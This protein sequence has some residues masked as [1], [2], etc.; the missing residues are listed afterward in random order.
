[1]GKFW[2]S[3]LIIIITLVLLPTNWWFCQGCLEEE[4]FALLQLKSNINNP[5]G[6]SLSSWIDNNR[7]DCCEWPNVVCDTSTKR[8]VQISLN[9]TR[10]WVVQGDWHF[11]ASLFL[12]FKMLRVLSLE[13]T[14]M[15]G[16][17]ENQGL[18][19]LPNSSKLEILNLE[20]NKFNRS[21]LLSLSGLTSLKSL[22]LGRNSLDGSGDERLQNL[23]RLEFLSLDGTGISDLQSVCSIHDF[24]N[25]K[26]LDISQNAF[27][28]L[29]PMHGIA[30]VSH[31]QVLHLDSLL[32]G[33]TSNYSNMIQSLSVLSS[34]NTLY[35][36]HNHFLETHYWKNLSKLENLFLDGSYLVDKNV[37]NNIGGL[38]SLKVIS[39]SECGLSGT[40][41]KQGWCEL[42][43]I[44]ELRL[45]GNELNGVLPPC[46][47][48]L[49]S[50]RL[51]DLSSNQFFGN[52]AISPLSRLTSLESLTIS[53]NQFQVPFSFESFSNHSNLKFIF[54]ANNEVILETS[55]KN[56][57]PSF[58]LEFFSLSNCV[59]QYHRL[60]SFLLHQNQLRIIDLT[61]NNVG[62]D[63]PNWLLE[64]N[65]KLEGFYMG[66]NAFKGY[67]KFPKKPN[68]HIGTIDISG[69]NISGQ[70][71][72]DINIFFPNIVVLN[73]S[74][75]NLVGSLPSSFWDLNS[76]EYLDLSNNNLMGELP[77]K[78]ATCC[79]SLQFLKLSNNKF[80]GQI[81]FPG[82]LNTYSLSAL[83]LDNNNFAGTI[84]DDL[85]TT[86][87]TLMGLDLSNNHLHGK[88]PKCIGNMSNIYLLSVSNNLLE[89][90]I[91]IEFCKLESIMLLDMSDN[92][93][94]GSI[95]SCFNP[96]RL[97][98]LYLSKNKFGGQL[99]QPFC[100][101]T[102]LA[103]LDLSDNNFRGKIPGWIGNLSTLN[104]LL[105]KGNSFEGVIP[106]QL[107]QLSHLMLQYMS[108]FDLSCNQLSGNIPSNLGKLSEIRA[109]NLSHNNLTGGIPITLSGL[110]KI[111]SLDL[112]YNKLNGRIPA[113]L[114][115]LNFLAVFSVAHNNLS[116]PIPDRKAQFATF[117]ASSYG[118]NALLCGPPLSNLCT[119]KE[120]S[121][122]Q[123]L[124]H[125]NGEEE[126]N[127]MDMKSFYIS[128]LI[129]YTVMLVTVVVVLCINPYWRRTWFSFIEFCAMSCYD[130][131][132][133]A[134]LNFKL[135]MRSI[136]SR[137]M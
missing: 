85:S 35:F 130:Y 40:L 120:L 88:L 25:L 62:G 117:D 77:Q 1:M 18:E 66:G 51:I 106:S 137:F 103:L 127:F 58:K 129:A 126:S 7:S 38:M 99:T 84:P 116:G 37:L 53:N 27:Q 93:L 33:S 108:G 21:V 71:P 76:L 19:K 11:N 32:G 15:V 81:V 83:L 112:S 44:Q 16:W 12:P 4:R 67:L 74:G 50:L 100:D 125:E 119:H 48:N 96:G 73:M 31:L 43:N 60:P 118:G 110:A 72:N 132:W 46:L 87:T 122:P 30:N 55:S 124:L 6:N 3:S 9:S 80:Q 92:M 82:A 94:S 5:N 59:G 102:S 95:P 52:I 135:R 136:H 104:V 39:L 64:N 65:T 90:L 29:G 69:N 63:F 23:K 20:G 36:R 91:P 131:V 98:H 114:I 22:K 109:L 134:F 57:V 79:Y 28:S 2:I 56:S 86:F 128:F 70:I 41:P 42:K 75:N 24:T 49:T 121:P 8:V 101:Q 115:A 10:I 107:C 17:V 26:E 89:G 78:L 123:V 45:S 13:Q 14:D 54:A 111:E 68:F 105:L 61:R 113:Q 47:G 133:I 34:L 97:A